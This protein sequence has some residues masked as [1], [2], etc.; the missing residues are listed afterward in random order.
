MLSMLRSHIRHNVVAYL[1]LF[2]ALTGVAYAAG[3]LKEGSPAGGDLTGTYPNPE[4]APN[5]V[6]SPEVGL[7]ALTGDDILESSLGTVP[8]ATNASQLN[9]QSA[10]FYQN[11]S[12]LDSGTLSS[13]RLSSTV[14]IDGDSA[15]GS[16]TGTYPNPTIASGAI[17]TSQFSNTIPAAGVQGSPQS[18]SGDESN[19]VLAFNSETYDSA[20][21]HSIATNTS[22]LTAPVAGVYNITANI[23]WNAETVVGGDSDGIS[24]GFRAIQAR[25]NGALT[26][27]ID[28]VAPVALSS[29]AQTFSTEAKLSA[30]DYVEVVVAQDSGST[31]NA[32]PISVTMSW[33]APG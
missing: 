20:A 23:I 12:N 7:N 30:L 21:L 29:T 32:S 10:S 8:S 24:D 4:I 33:V 27:A 13:D 25:Q 1:A 16:L 15:G 19:N 17:G 28:K 5:A 11:A 6:G 22:R 9:G 3:P 14:L 31:L 18:T 2:F 26:L